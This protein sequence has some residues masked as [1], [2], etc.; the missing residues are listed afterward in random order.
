MPFFQAGLLA[1][2]NRNL[3]MG[4]QVIRREPDGSYSRRDYRRNIT[5]ETN[6]NLLAF[7]ESLGR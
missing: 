4:H 3:A 2:L 7:A 6:V 1:K 5:I